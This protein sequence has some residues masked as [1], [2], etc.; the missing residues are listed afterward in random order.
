VIGVPAK[1]CFG[2]VEARGFDPF[3][4]DAGALFH[5]IEHANRY[6]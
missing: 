3:D 2:L 6:A 4:A 1:E 5:K